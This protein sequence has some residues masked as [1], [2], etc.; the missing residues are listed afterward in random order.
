LEAYTTH[1]LNS[2]EYKPAFKIEEED[3]PKVVSEED[4]KLMD[5]QLRQN[6]R[7]ILELIELK[8]T[9]SLNVIT[10]NVCEAFEESYEAYRIDESVF[11]IECDQMLRRDEYS[12]HYSLYHDFLLPYSEEIHHS[13]PMKQ[14]GC[15]Y[16]DT[17]Y[18]FSFSKD[19]NNKIQS[20]QIANLIYNDSNNMLAFCLFNNN[21]YQQNNDYT[22]S[23]NP[24]LFE[25]LPFD[26][27]Y[28]ILEYLD[29]FS[30]FNLS[31]T[32]KVLK[33]FN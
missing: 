30:L 24:K 29:S 4:I 27:V 21:N 19:V 2:K 7:D 10:D 11:K 3:E 23:N 33:T 25:D 20:S 9:I 14:Y 15:Q 12:D 26:I 32:S 5:E 22:Y 18:L 1:F 13:C 31:Q 28:A 6:N 17:N 8:D 16:F